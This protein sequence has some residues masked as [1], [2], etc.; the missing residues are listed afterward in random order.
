MYDHLDCRSVD[1]VALTD[2]LDMWLDDEGLDRHSINAPATLIAQIYGIT[3]QPYFGPVLPC[4]HDDEGNS[5][6][7][8]VH[9]I[10][11]LVGRIQAITEIPA[12]P[13]RSG[14]PHLN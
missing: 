6:D 2:E 9:V 5:I 11:D 8:P 4:S 7:M 1:V 13:T 10:A 3:H 12:L 14:P